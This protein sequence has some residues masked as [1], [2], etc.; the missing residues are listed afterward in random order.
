MKTMRER[1]AIYGHGSNY[2]SKITKKLSG[3]YEYNAKIN[4]STLFCN[5][6]SETEALIPDMHVSKKSHNY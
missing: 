5:L 3:Q 2:I 1:S 6:N 4:I